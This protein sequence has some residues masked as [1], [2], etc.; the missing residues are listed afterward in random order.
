[1]CAT[2]RNG[3][4]HEAPQRQHWLIAVFPDES[5]AHHAARR[6]GA[7]GADPDAVRI[8]DPLDALAS[9]GGEMREEVSHVPAVPVPFTREAVRG[10]TVGTVIGAVVGVVVAL[11]FA[12]I[13]V[14]DLP[15]STRLVIVGV[16][17]L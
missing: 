14:G 15:L 16:V 10:F 11:P 5:S 13:P 4:M 7:A 12:A 3:S 9:V 1:M 2:G 8:G 6:A 17:G